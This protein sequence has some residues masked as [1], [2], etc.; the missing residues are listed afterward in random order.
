M[1][2]GEASAE[3]AL[4]PASAF[5][6]LLGLVG[7]GFSGLLEVGGGLGL[8]GGGGFALLE[9]GGG[10]GLMGGGG[11][12]LSEVDGG[13]GLDRGLVVDGGAD[14]ATEVPR[15]PMAGD[16]ASVTPRGGWGPRE[17]AGAGVAGDPIGTGGEKSGGNSSGGSGGKDGA[18]VGG[19]AAKRSPPAITGPG[20]ERIGI[21]MSATAA[22]SP[23]A[24]MTMM[25]SLT[26][27]IPTSGRLP[28]TP[29]MSSTTRLLELPPH[30]SSTA[31]GYWNRSI[32]TSSI[33]STPSGLAVS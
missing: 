22:A 21:S 15:T 31:E 24:A 8:A 26:L 13:L 33:C 14:S 17:R 4:R 3:V 11:V 12:A 16:D 30:R 28:L 9:V 29:P 32:G 19:G 1:D 6:L 27:R 20:A 2:L 5:I 10:L 18:L 25:I 7:W 23:A